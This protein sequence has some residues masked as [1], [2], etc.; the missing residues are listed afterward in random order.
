[1][2]RRVRRLLIWS[3]ASILAAGVA[4]CDSCERHRDLPDP[5]V[6]ASH[7]QLSKRDLGAHQSTRR[8]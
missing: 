6:P 2:I 1:M 3:L 4:A 5:E 8:P 7:E